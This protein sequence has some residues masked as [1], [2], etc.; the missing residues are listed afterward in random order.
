MSSPPS[1]T[2]GLPSAHS[3]PCPR[4]SQGGLAGSSVSSSHGGRE[5][6]PP[7]GPAAARVSPYPRGLSVLYGRG[8][9]GEK[10]ASAVPFSVTPL[11]PHGLP[12]PSGWSPGSGTSRCCAPWPVPPQP[13]SLGTRHVLSSLRAF[14]L[15]VLAPPGPCQAPK[16]APRLW[17]WAF[18]GLPTEDVVGLAGHGAPGFHS[19][20]PLSPLGCGGSTGLSG[21]LR[22]LQA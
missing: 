15:G 6:P 17:A 21:P 11:Q 4:S 9:A 3:H 16:A 1:F 20:P 12:L 10:S 7:Q 13:C 14:V 18:H 2:Q 5:T 19:A 8:A 22:A